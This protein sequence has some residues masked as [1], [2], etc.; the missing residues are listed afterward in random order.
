MDAILL[1]TGTITNFK[2]LSLGLRSVPAPAWGPCPAGTFEKARDHPW[3]KG[4]VISEG[5]ILI[6]VY[7][8]YLLIYSNNANNSGLK[9]FF[10]DH[11]P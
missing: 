6:I 9:N 1:S 5:K 7:N 11:V 4:L 10:L 3:F 8:K 2:T